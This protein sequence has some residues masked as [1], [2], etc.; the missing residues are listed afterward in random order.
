LSNFDVLIRGGDLVD[1][2]GSEARVADV[3]IRGDRIAAIGHLSAN[4]AA[5]VIAAEG[6]VVCPGFVDIQ[7]QS[8]L[9]LLASGDAESHIR[10]GITS[11]LIGEGGSPGQVTPRVLARNPRYAEWVDSLGLRVD[12]SGFRGYF[13]RLERSG[14]SVNLGAFASM[15]LLRIETVGYENR[16]PSAS[17]LGEM[18]AILDRAMREGAFGL[19]TALA[20]PP[21]SFS[22]TEELV[23]LARIA[24]AHGGIYISHVRGES[25]GVLAAID[26]AI[27]IGK[28]A[29]LPVVVF[30][31]KVAGRANW[32]R[33]PEVGALIEAA[34]A[35]GGLVSACQYPY[36]MAG[37]GL[38]A[39]LPEWVL[40]GGPDTLLGRLRDPSTRARVRQE[41]ESRDAL[42]GRVDFEA[43]QIAEVPKGS[44]P[45]LVSKRVAEIARFTGEDPF[46]AYFRILI[47]T[48]GAAFALYHSMSEGDVR[49]AMA[50]PWVSIATDAEATS[51]RGVLGRALVHP[52][53]Y[54]TFPR[55]LGRYVREARLLSLPDAIR[56]M[57]SLPASQVGLTERGVIREGAFADIV[58]LDPTTVVD[59]ATCEQPHQFPTGIRWVIVNGVVTVDEA[60]HTGA[61]SGRVLRRGAS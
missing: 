51:P 58:V 25:G 28:E 16:P 6:H 52:R 4:G 13:D 29:R 40:D 42:L 61:R 57:T 37:T 26:E 60:E 55:V 21:A 11:E 18:Q 53:A 47:E 9:S 54:G 22:S 14:T 49:T 2:T 10:Q 32:G 8:V 41:M 7:S 1:G 5:R 31:L 27:T 33:M 39:P 56:K 48:R 17:E 34:R 3:G 12:W 36:T 46:D 35:Q 38:A 59:T 19:A 50:F 30:H 45:S 23:A 20:Y 15:D 24:S 43:I 44:D